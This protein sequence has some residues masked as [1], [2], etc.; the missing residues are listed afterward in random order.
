MLGVGNVGKPR[1][2]ALLKSRCHPRMR[3]RIFIVDLPHAAGIIDQQTISGAWPRR[4]WDRLRRKILFGPPR[5]VVVERRCPR[6]ELD[7]DGTV[8]VHAVAYGPDGTPMN[9]GA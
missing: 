8:S 2:A 3:R 9:W 1:S 7:D 6:V 5:G 4:T